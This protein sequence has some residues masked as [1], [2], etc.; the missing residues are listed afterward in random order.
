MGASRWTGLLAA[1]L[2]LGGAGGCP[3]NPGECF[4]VS[5]PQ[6]PDTRVVGEGEPVSLTILP[7]LPAGCDANTPPRLPE[8]VTVEVYD[9]D[10][11]PVPAT[12]TL[13][14]GAT[15]ATVRFTPTVKGRHHVIVA[16][17]PVGSLHQI[18]V[19]AVGDRR[20]EAPLARFTN[21][22]F[23][24]YLDRTLQG[25]W[26]CDARP[27]R[28]PAS[29]FQQ[30]ATSS[31]A[32]VAVAGDVVW[33]VDQNRVLRYV[34]RGSGPLALTGSAPLVGSQTGGV[35]ALN[36]DARLATPEELVL[37][38]GTLLARYT[39]TDSGGVANALTSA[40]S[41]PQGGPIPVGMDAATALLVRAGARLLVV[42]RVNDSQ[43]FKPR[44]E[45]C[46]FQLGTQGA[47]TRVANEPCQS[48][49]GEPMGYEEGVLWTRTSDASLGPLV[50]VLHRY[51]A[52]SGLLVEEGVLSLDGNLVVNT[53]PLR[54]GPIRPSLATL[55]AT[56]RSYAAADWN[57]ARAALELELVPGDAN[58]E[59]PQLGARYIW[60]RSFNDVAVYPRASTR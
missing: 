30:L 15:S 56:S 31:T 55:G 42:V 58:N 60:Q 25:T 28:N 7:A 22:T 59:P 5:P 19:F 47:Y 38:R 52:A 21:E 13:E 8:S 45:A 16:F 53:A 41:L 44:F 10:N 3:G 27:L 4:N 36:T 34:D 37:M 20:G 57:P 35:N 11:Q 50:E 43:T 29:S 33:V 49:E 1:L 39:V 24:L 18:G 48:F 40:W 32:S 6:R 9:P 54:P 14:A 12:A 2:V 51:T 23:C 17:A 46:P 26:L